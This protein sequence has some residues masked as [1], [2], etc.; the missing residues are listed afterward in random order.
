[1]YYYRH[2]ITM[3]FS[4]PPP[5]LFCLPSVNFLIA[6]KSGYQSSL[7]QASQHNVENELT[8]ETPYLKT[9]KHL[10]AATPG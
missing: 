9:R 3:V 10:N 5:N 4:V 6:G 8:E 1:M 7:Y 2:A